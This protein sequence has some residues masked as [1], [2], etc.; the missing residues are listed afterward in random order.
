MAAVKVLKHSAHHRPPSK[1]LTSRGCSCLGD[2][3]E[4]GGL[5]VRRGEQ[6]I[7]ERLRQDPRLMGW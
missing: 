2:M 1:E 5:A 6:D 3:P 4:M 7:L